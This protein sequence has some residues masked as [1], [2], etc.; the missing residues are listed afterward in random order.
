MNDDDDLLNGITTHVFC[1][2]NYL[3]TASSSQ[4]GK[5]LTKHQQLKIPYF[6]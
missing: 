1:I 5:Q 3:A 6:A 4:I 2:N